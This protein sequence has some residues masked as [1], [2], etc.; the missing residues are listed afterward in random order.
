MGPN[1]Q[2]L[3]ADV[4]MIRGLVGEKLTLEAFTQLSGNLAGYPFVKLVIDS[5]PSE[6][7]SPQIHFINHQ[8][9]QFHSD[10]IAEAILQV[11]P[12]SIDQN[13]DEF[14][15]SVYLSPDRR[16]CLGILAL[17][18]TSLDAPTTEGQ[19]AERFFTLETVEIDNMDS[20]LVQFFYDT[21]KTHVDRDFPIFFKPANIQQESMMTKIDSALLPRVFSHELMASAQ[22][23]A[24]NTGTA[25]GR[26]RAFKSEAAYRQA[27]ATLEW[28]DIIVMRRVPDDIPRVSGIINAH[29]TTPLS[30]TN[31]L[32]SGWQIPNAIQI[33]IF[34]QVDEQGLDGQWVNYA[35]DANA[36]QVGLSK[37]ARPVELNQRPAWSVQR[38][39]LEEPETMH[40]PIVELQALRMSD[41]YRYGTK[42]AN[43]GELRNVLERGSERLMGFY[44]IKRPP[45]VNLLPFLAQFLGMPEKIEPQN[46]GKKASEFLRTTVQVPRGIAIPFSVQQEFLE[47][48]PRIQQAIGKLKMALEFEARETDALCLTLQSLIRQTRV[49]EKIRNYIDSQI[50]NELAGVSKFVVRSSS[51][52]EDLE[53]FSAAGIYESIN[54]VA[55]ADNIFQ[56]I[57]EVWASL[58]SPRSVRLRHEVGISLDDCYMGVIIQEEVE[59]QIGGVLVTTNPMNRA[60]DFRNVYINVSSKS[61]T[62]IVQGTDM[63]FQYLFN[64]VEGGGRTL[65][66]GNAKED[67]LPAQKDLLQKLAFAGRLLQ[68][69]FSPDYTFSHPVDIEWVANDD[70][71][72]IVQLRPYSK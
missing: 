65:S 42:A 16:F 7:K 54:H 47:S 5:K 34:E 61:V 28:Y 19:R 70:G 12:S 17:Q 53:N 27:R 10:Y 36:P 55:T 63:P 57:K 67:L 68:S 66:L 64:T 43:L 2:A 44:R 58:V 32:A 48:S 72:F 9:Y 56:S 15:R 33:G 40:T 39:K 3:L 38:I 22:Y 23:I 31:V 8:R 49:P 37:I 13:I 18:K 50:A 20:T 45:R 52:A 25:R 62:N 26:L 69:H 51:N 29:H 59:A 21:V 4:E 24:L 71:L 46:L 30:H 41:R 14:N 60:G 35:V 6:G 1:S 11:T